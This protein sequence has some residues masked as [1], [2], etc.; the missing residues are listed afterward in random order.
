[1]DALERIISTDTVSANP[2]AKAAMPLERELSTYDSSLMDLLASEGKYILI[3][4]DNVNG[5]FDSY[6]D[7]LKAGYEK[8]GLATFLVKQIA[9][10]EPI[11]Y[12][13]RDLSACRS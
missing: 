2:T 6:D 13:S 12:F 9:R 3:S 10:A 4:G 1:M 8:F 11:H 7:A 5:V